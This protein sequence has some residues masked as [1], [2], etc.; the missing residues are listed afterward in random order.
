MDHK[1]ELMALLNEFAVGGII[2]LVIL[3]QPLIVGTYAM[4]E[5]SDI[6]QVIVHLAVVPKH[7]I[8]KRQV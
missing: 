2:G 3:S 7:Q 4:Y 5:G 6:L 1:A 8:D